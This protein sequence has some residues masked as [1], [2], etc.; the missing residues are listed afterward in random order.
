MSNKKLSRVQMYP[1]TDPD[2]SLDKK[3][4]FLLQA[5]QLTQLGMRHVNKVLLSRIWQHIRH[6]QRPIKPR[7][8][9]SRGLK[10]LE[11]ESLLVIKLNSDVWSQEDIED[12]S[13]KQEN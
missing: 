12:K 6:W 1:N 2:F 3:I 10:L 13:G 5:A 4:R 7:I 8:L 11:M 9:I